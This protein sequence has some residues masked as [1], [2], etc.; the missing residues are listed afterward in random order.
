[1]VQLQIF[2]GLTFETV[3]EGVPPVHLKGIFQKQIISD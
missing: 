2:L 3:G 1:M